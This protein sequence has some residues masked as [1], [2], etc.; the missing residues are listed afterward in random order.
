MATQ[1]ERGAP[2]ARPDLR[3]ARVTVRPRI[4][5]GHNGEFATPD[6]LR[7]RRTEIEAALLLGMRFSPHAHPGLAVEV[8]WTMRAGASS[9]PL[10]ATT[11]SGAVLAPDDRC[12]RDLQFLAAEAI[13]MACD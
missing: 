8:D 13:M 4:L 12:L 5:A 9:A 11:R 1:L 3:I 10:E 2:H 6:L 7:T